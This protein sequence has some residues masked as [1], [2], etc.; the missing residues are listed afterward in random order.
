MNIK[1]ISSSAVKNSIF[2]MSA[3]T[4]ENADIFT[5]GDE[6]YLVFAPEKYIFFLFYTQRKYIK[7]KQLLSSS[8]LFD[9]TFAVCLLG[10]TLGVNRLVGA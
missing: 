9:L 10:I 3:S 7:H 8:F 6:I 5:T 1:Y 4:S 2:F